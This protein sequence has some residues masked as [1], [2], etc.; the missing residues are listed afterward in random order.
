[1][2]LEMPA[3]L[4][5]H[6]VTTKRMYADAV[7]GLPSGYAIRAMRR[8]R[9]GSLGDGKWC[10]KPG[11]LRQ[12]IIAAIGVDA[13]AQKARESAEESIEES[14]LYRERLASR[15]DAERERVAKL[16]GEYR[17]HLD[18]IAPAGPVGPQWRPPT[19]AEASEWIA[20]HEN[21]ASLRPVNDF[22]EK[23]IAQLLG[24]EPIGTGKLGAKPVE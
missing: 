5:S 24:E 14:R 23:L 15:S 12:A 10:P 18:E 13:K 2:A 3:D 9:V 19:D 8:F 7:A 20:T 4:K 11:E 21:G 6:P 22:S 1:M 17:A 16:V